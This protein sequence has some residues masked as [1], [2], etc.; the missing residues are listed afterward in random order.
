MPTEVRGEAEELF[1]REYLVQH[2]VF[3]QLVRRYV[4]DSANVIEKGRMNLIIPSLKH[5]RFGVN[6]D[7]PINGVISILHC[8]NFITPDWQI[9]HPVRCVPAEI[10]TRNHGGADRLLEFEGVIGILGRKKPRDDRGTIKRLAAA[11]VK[12]LEIIIDEFPKLIRA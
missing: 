7:E 2:W 9:R 12:H 4:M 10:S 1:R 11:G 8:I 5:Q 3:L 6:A